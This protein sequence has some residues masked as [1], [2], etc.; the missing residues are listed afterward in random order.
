MPFSRTS[1]RSKLAARDAA[2]SSGPSQHEADASRHVAFPEN[3]KGKKGKRK[4]GKR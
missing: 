2:R 4:K 1:F 3:K